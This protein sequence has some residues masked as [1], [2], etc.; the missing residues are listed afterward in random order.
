MVKCTANI[1]QIEKWVLTEAQQLQHI[2]TGMCLDC[3]QLRANDHLYARECDP[4]SSSQKWK[5][6]R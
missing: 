5:I 4:L 1:M 6:E 2:P 3:V